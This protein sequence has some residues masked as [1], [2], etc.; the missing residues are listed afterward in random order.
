M[1]TRSARGYVSVNF[2]T[3][4]SFSPQWSKASEAVDLV[5]FAGASEGLQTWLGQKPQNSQDC[6]KPC[7]SNE[8][9]HTN[10]KVKKRDSVQTW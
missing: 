2:V 8:K 4:M 9:K 6:G 1:I 3:T 10:R 5:G 7:R